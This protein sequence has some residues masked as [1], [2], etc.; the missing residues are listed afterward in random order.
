M[1]AK[2][3][4]VEVMDRILPVE[5]HE[6]ISAFVRKSLRKTAA[7]SIITGAEVKK[8]DKASGQCDRDMLSMMAGKTESVIDF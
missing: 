7:S 4:V 2:V 8:L 5:D 3:T 1:G 6:E